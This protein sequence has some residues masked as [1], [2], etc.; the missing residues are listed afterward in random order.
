VL[1]GESAGF[2]DSSAFN[3]SFSAFKLSNST[4]SV[5]LIDF[6]VVPLTSDASTSSSTST[7][8]SLYSVL[9]SASFFH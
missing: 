5:V 4:T 6:G 7:S 1:I 8:S 2:L 3:L 9:S